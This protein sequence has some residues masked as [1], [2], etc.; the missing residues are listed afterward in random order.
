MSLIVCA[1][2]SS[3]E[4]S[5]YGRFFGVRERIRTFETAVD[6][7]FDGLSIAPGG[8]ALPVVVFVHGL[9]T[10]ILS[11]IDEFPPSQV[12]GLTQLPS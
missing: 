1:T 12:Y 3:R 5:T 11:L 2:V 4:S 10:A 9:T 6:A 8:A 7:H